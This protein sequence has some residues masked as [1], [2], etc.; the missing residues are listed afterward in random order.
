MHTEAWDNLCNMLVILI[1]PQELLS[2]FC[3]LC[4]SLALRLLRSTRQRESQEGNK[5][6]LEYYLLSHP[7]SRPRIF[8]VNPLHLWT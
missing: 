7:S 2:T 8:T 6:P 5:K 1:D 4:S 3:G